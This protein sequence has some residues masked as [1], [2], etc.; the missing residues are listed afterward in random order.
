M[1]LGALTHHDT[2]ALLAATQVA[3]LW[4]HGGDEQAIASAF[5]SIVLEMQPHTRYLAFHAIAHVGEW[6]NRAQL[7]HLAQLP[8]EDV[9]GRPEC[10]YGPRVQAVQVAA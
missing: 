5:R 4:I 7:W 6:D 1:K 8:Q 10:K 3:A 9:L 2:T